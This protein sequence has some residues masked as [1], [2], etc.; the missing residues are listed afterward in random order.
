M[1]QGT[2]SN[3]G[4]SL[5]T[6]ALCRV[7]K[8]DG[9][10]VAPF[11]AQN[12]SNNSF[13]THD[14]KEVARAQVV[15]AQAC[16]LEP[17]ARFSPIL[18]K[19]TSD[20]NSQII[21]QGKAISNM[22]IFE[23]HKFKNK[24]FELVKE[25]Y[26]SLLDEYDVIILEGAGS[27]AE[28]NLKEHDIVNMN[29]AKVCNTPVLLVGDIHL[30]GIYASFV[31]HYH[32]FNNWEKDLL[33]GF[34]VNRFR[35]E[36]SLLERAHDDLYKY[37]QKPVYG[38]IPYINELNIPEEDSVNF[39]AI[40]HENH[41]EMN[42]LD[43][44]I[45]DLPHI[46]NFT[47]FDALKNEKCISLRKVTKPENFNHPDLVIIPGSKNTI[48]DI[49]HIINNGLAKQIL[50]YS[51]LKSSTIIGICG[52]FQMLGKSIQDPHLIEGSLTQCE[53][54]GLLNMHTEMKE[55]KS[56]RQIRTK[57]IPSGTEVNGYEIHH[58]ESNQHQCKE[59]FLHENC[60]LGYSN[61]D[62][63]IWGTYIHG[64]FDSKNFRQW[65]INSLLKTKGFEPIIVNSTQYSLE[66]EFNKL[67][68]TF[69]ENVDM[70]SI[71]KL[72]NL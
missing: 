24:A 67:A 19:P 50:Q 35:G 37:T 4:K 58:G 53:G 44:V 7:L 29:M 49:N 13:V 3:A 20:K 43:V 51:R 52:G 47:D 32:L 55:L 56:L 41:T 68:N 27:P 8:Q 69:R 9:V 70:K 63:N 23:Y 38:V 57:H 62:N 11:K 25:D 59:I 21:L 28:I 60:N 45:I 72:L 66:S 42:T 64:I 2:S 33:K 65:F 22:S 17:D 12:M 39:K 18:L 1:F 30:G 31:G 48:S 71:Y 26:D 40:N 46:S 10:K 61:Q 16:G 54:L 15:Q 6:S 36:Q 14:N 34:I 5:M